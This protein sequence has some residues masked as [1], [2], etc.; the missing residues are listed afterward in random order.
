VLEIFVDWVVDIVVL[1]ANDNDLWT[2]DTSYISIRSVLA[3]AE[4]GWA[5][6]CGQYGWES[7][8]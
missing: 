1:M 7:C 3:A 2:A 6:C 5:K 8:G 4:D